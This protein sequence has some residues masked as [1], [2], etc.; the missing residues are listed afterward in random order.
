MKFLLVIGLLASGTTGAV[1]E[2]K[3]AWPDGRRAAILLTYDDAIRASDLD[4]AAPQLDLVQLKGTFFLMGKA[5]RADDVAAGALR[6]PDGEGALQLQHGRREVHVVRPRVR[7][8]S[9][10]RCPRP[11][12]KH[13]KR[14]TPLPLKSSGPFTSCLYLVSTSAQTTGRFSRLPPQW[15]LV[16]SSGLPVPW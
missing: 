16:A 3:F 1:A 2:P 8:Q 9:S 11:C 6:L 5:M 10:S 7:A 15:K 12:R 14:W 4:V 13:W